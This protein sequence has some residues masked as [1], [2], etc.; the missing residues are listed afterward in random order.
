MDKKSL[1]RVEIKDESRGEVEAVFAT[2]DVV[3]KDNDVTRKGAFESG[4]EV[5]ISAYNHKTWEGAL[6]VGKGVI[7]EVGDRVVMKGQ[8]FMNTTHGRDHFEVVK[9]LGAKQ[10]WSYGFNVDESEPGEFEG[11]SVRVLK[12]MTVHE[13]SPV[14]RGAGVGTHTTYAKGHK[15]LNEEVTAV[16]AA[17]DSVIESAGRVVA[18][19]AQKGKELSRVNAGSLDGLAA[20][21][22]ELKALLSAEET[23]EADDDTDLILSLVTA[24]LESE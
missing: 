19:R 6:P 2:L 15:T 22:D 7:Q 8:F 21:L 12:R 3:D 24:E 10:E 20:K 9:A 13:V 23:P 16:V 18:L 17:V 14:L 4:A 11:K 5:V 1:A